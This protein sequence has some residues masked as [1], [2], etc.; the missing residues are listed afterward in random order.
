MSW[1][2]RAIVFLYGRLLC[3]Y[4]PAFRREMAAEM[5]AVFS[6]ILVAAT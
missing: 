1:L 2:L 5:M 3:L 4:P 6:Q